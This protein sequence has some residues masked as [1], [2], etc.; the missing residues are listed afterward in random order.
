MKEP[1]VLV[2]FENVQKLDLARLPAQ[3]RIRI[4]IG[5]QQPKLPTAL[6]LE[7]QKPGRSVEWIKIESTGIR[8]TCRRRQRRQHWNKL[9]FYPRT[10]RPSS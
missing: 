10:G 4:F 7:A 5:A 3:A 2:D 9:R 1:V 8:R 6:V